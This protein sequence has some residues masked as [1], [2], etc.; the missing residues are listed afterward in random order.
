MADQTIQLLLGDCIER[1]KGLEEGSIEAVVTDP[2]YLI[3]FM[4][5][6]WDSVVNPAEWY[7]TWLKECHRVLVPGGRIKVFGGTRM[8][9]RMEAAVEQAGFILLDE[10]GWAYGSGFPKSLSVSKALDKA[11]GRSEDR[12]VVGINPS[13]RPNSK[14]R[15]QVVSIP[16]RGRMNLRGSRYSP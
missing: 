15:M 13:S 10:I 9:H 12:E 11:L 16:S 2:P 6:V 8:K 1:M 3:S 5:R 7:V 14:R 4:N